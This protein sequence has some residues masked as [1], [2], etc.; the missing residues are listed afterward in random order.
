MSSLPPSG[1]TRPARTAGLILLGVA[2]IAVGLGVFALTSSGNSHPAAAS[3]STN[4]PAPTTTASRPATK[5][6][7]TSP[8]TTTKPP[9]TTPAGPPVGPTTTIAPPPTTTTPDGGVPGIGQV[10]VRVYNNGTIKGLAA[11]ATADFTQAGFD[12]VETGNYS[13]GSIP[14]STVYYTS[15]PGEQATATALGQ[16]FGM[17]VQP[18]FP[19]IAY[20]SPGVIVIVTNDF[21]G[22]GGGGS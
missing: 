17:R 2:V 4:Q 7:T 13:Q 18:R 19:G 22:H 15:L 1:P 21:K 11:A 9:T 6:A 10:Q 12:V 8:A 3:T 14:T 5:P 16:Q 20:A